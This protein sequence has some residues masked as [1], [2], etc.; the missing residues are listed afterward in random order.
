MKKE[1][2]EFVHHYFYTDQDYLERYMTVLTME[3]GDII[4]YFVVPMP[5]WFTFNDVRYKFYPFC[6]N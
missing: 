3:N 4:N 2:Q 1:K 5:A 6:H